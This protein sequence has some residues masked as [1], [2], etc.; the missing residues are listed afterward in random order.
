MFRCEKF[1]KNTKSAI[2]AKILGMTF[3]NNLEWSA[4]FEKGGETV[5]N[6][7]KR[8]LGFLKNMARDCSIEFRRKLADG[9]VMSRLTYRIQFW[10]LSINNHL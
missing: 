4:H 5:I 6:K 1:Q 3:Q 10:G 9:C 8:K 2:S 7:C